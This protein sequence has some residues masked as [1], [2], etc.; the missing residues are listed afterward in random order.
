M[1]VSAGAAP[2][3][4]RFG[5]FE[6]NLDTLELRRKGA[7]VKLEGQPVRLLAALV[8]RPGEVLSREELKTALWTGETFVDFD[9][10]INVA[11]QRLREALD[12]SA[13]APR[14]VETLPR[15][16]Y[17]F[18]Y[19]VGAPPPE[20]APRQP[21][22]KAPR[23]WA[24]TAGVVIVAVVLLAF[25]GLRN[26]FSGRQSGVRGGDAA[27]V[28]AHAA[29][30]GA[31]GQGLYLVR[32]GTTEDA[33]KARTLFE[34]ALESD[35]TFAPAYAQLAL[36]FARSGNGVRLTPGGPP[37]TF[38]GPP[39]RRTLARTYANKALALAPTLA[40]PHAALAWVDMAD[41]DWQG[42]E[43]HFRR[44]IELDPALTIAHVWYGVYLSL[45]GR[46]TEAFEHV[47]Y[48]RRADPQPNVLLP[49]AGLYLRLRRPD[50]AMTIAEAVLQLEG[51]AWLGHALLGDA[52]LQKG[53]CSEAIAAYEKAIALHPEGADNVMGGLARA[54]AKHG[55]PQEAR[56]ILATFERITKTRDVAPYA[57]IEVHIALAEYD[58]AL[59]WI[60]K[61]YDRHGETIIMLNQELFDPVRSHP[62]FQEVLR[63]VGLPAE[64]TAALATV[65]SGARR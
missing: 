37:P 30:L 25:A 46:A 34:Q 3:L 7:K 14:F 54:Y 1:P 27:V 13:T 12:D 58:R 10:S 64:N 65:P 28:G 43:G 63:R 53:M 52:Y 47:D 11:V 31:F 62:R 15:R 26:A 39:E 49:A 61:S 32:K 17:R 50:D 45:M 33:Q 55:E 16:G 29:A 41:W 56:R 60:E 24:V 18:I 2:R 20:P 57:W 44:A 23:R 35:S 40:E 4:V 48:A 5:T 38:R 42:A 22:P 36:L 6:L 9:H 21:A 19:P 51:N 8:D 59:E